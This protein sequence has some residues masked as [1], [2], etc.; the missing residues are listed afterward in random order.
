MDIDE[1]DIKQVTHEFASSLVIGSNNVSGI[2]SLPQPL[3]LGSFYKRH[4]IV[5]SGGAALSLYFDKGRRFHDIDLFVVMK[6]DNG[7]HRQTII[8]DLEAHGWKTIPRPGPPSL[9]EYQSLWNYPSTNTYFSYPETDLVLEITFFW[10]VEPATTV[11]QIIFNHFD[12]DLCSLVYDGSW[13][14][15]PGLS[16]NDVHSKRM[17]YRHENPL[18]RGHLGCSWMRQQRTLMAQH[19]LHRFHKYEGRGFTI[20]N[21]KDICTSMLS[22]VADPEVILCRLL[23]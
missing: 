7:L 8:K 22:T 15:P 23:L 1:P 12:L 2:D 16:E 21:K 10:F 11:E 20:T 4:G 17:R 14:L 13:K 19:I 3:G 5:M 18:E 6:D 9:V